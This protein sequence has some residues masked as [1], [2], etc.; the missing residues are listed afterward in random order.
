[1]LI[2]ME[3]HAEGHRT[4][5]SGWLR[6]AVLGADDGLVSTAALVVG[7]VASGASRTAIAT[8][9]VAALFAGALAMSIGEYVSVSTQADTERADRRRESR[10]LERDPEQELL[11][12]QWIYEQRG[13]SPELA[14][15]VAGAL[16]DN[17]ALEAHLRDELGHAEVTRV[18]PVQAA[19]VSALSFAAGAILPLLAVVSAP[20]STRIPIVALVTVMAMCSLGAVGA[21][22]GGAPARRG[23]LRVGIGGTLALAITYGVG[24]ALGASV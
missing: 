1:M 14:A 18:R 5:R 7:L 20:V 10:E 4:G 8:A 6:A 16:H 13:L 12:L 24:L 15:T 11:E 21:Q 17:G 2:V 3:I 22:L 23:A 9:A 19:V